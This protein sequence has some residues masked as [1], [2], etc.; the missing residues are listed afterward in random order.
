MIPTRE[1]TPDDYVLLLNARDDKGFGFILDVAAKCPQI[2]FVAVA[3]QT[4][5]SEARSAVGAKGLTNVTILARTDDVD[6]LYRKSKVVAV[7][8]Y[9]FVETFSRVCIEAQRFGK[10][11]IG[12]DV[13]NVPKLL[14]KSGIVLPEDASTWAAELSRL[15]DDSDYYLTRSNAAVR[16]SDLYSYKNQQT[17]ISEIVRTAESP[18]LLGIGSGIGNMTHVS[19]L[20][21]HLAEKLGH[22]I[23][24][25]VSEDYS[26]SLFL[27]QNSKWV[28]SVFSLRQAVLA[29]RYDTIFITHCFG[30]ARLPFTARRLIW[31]RDWDEFRAD[32]RLHEAH[33]NFEAA[34]QLLGID[35]SDDDIRKYYIGEIDYS[36]PAGNLVGFHG[37][38]KVG[39][40]ASKRWPYYS[41]LA[42]KLQGLGFRVA[43]F[44]TQEEY[45][46]GTED[47][48]GGT[49]EE[50]ALRMCNC[51]YFIG[52]DSGVMHVANSLGIPLLALFGPTNPLTRR[53]MQPTS[54]VIA[55]EKYCAPC[56][57]VNKEVFQ[58]GKC[59]C[60]SEIPLTRVL[61][62]FQDL[63]QHY[64]QS[65][66]AGEP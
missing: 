54:R 31:S 1:R 64:R 10:P 35:Y 15:F 58:T 52:N 17:A 20:I 29:R 16:N 11:V 33:F 41:E 63:T 65:P 2:D 36:W 25:V 7:P 18:F 23:D 4:E 24:I 28:N 5:Q 21:R 6:S 12:S 22:R 44:G 51:S 42:E 9:K 32:H 8:S 61:A 53:P 49:I 62:S 38:S 48:T 59:R 37:G 14:A 40:W 19:P 66:P 30:P 13:G 3:S 26:E 56:E 45:L 43:S 34:K 57:C 55:L 27:L 60:I 47:M 39:F 46:E 50:M